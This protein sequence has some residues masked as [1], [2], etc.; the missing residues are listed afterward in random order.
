MF[1][2][3]FIVFRN[4][5]FLLFILVSATPP[6]VRSEKR[7]TTPNSLKTVRISSP[8]VT[9]VHQRRTI[10]PRSPRSERKSHIWQSQVDGKLYVLEQFSIPRYYRLYNDVSF[11]ELFQFSR[12]LDHYI[13][14]TEKN[15]QNYSNLLKSFALDQQQRNLMKT[16]S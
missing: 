10:S 9:S 5:T 6:P 7:S 4:K 3:I 13:D 12:L 2:F 8:P 15:I 16:S 1:V 14:P 11:R